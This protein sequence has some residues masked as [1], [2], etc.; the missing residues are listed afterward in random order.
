MHL[1]LEI[2]D[3][4]R[5]PREADAPPVPPKAAMS[6]QRST[7]SSY[8]GL[9]RNGSA[10]ERGTRAKGFLQRLGKDTKGLFDGF[11]GKARHQEDADSPPRSPVKDRFTPTSG[12]PGTAP[13]NNSESPSSSRPG[14]PMTS[15][16]TDKHVEL[17]HKLEH[18]LPSTTP[19]LA[20]PM[21]AVL[22]RVQ[23]ERRLWK[24]K[25]LQETPTA[26]SSAFRLP[27]TMG[28]SAFSAAFGQDIPATGTASRSYRVGGDVRTGLGVLMS[29][30]ETFGGWQKLQRL[31]VLRA[32]RVQP[33]I[34]KL[35]S[36]ETED[37]SLCEKPT[38]TRFA[39]WS[40]TLEES[41]ASFTAGLLEN[42][43]VCKKPG[44]VVE[45]EGHQTLWYHNHSKVI[46]HVHKDPGP[47]V[48]GEQIDAWIKCT[49]CDSR[50]QPRPLTQ[51]AA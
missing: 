3:T 12:L 4:F 5:V 48:A 8:G 36:K 9:K 35:S 20:L 27:G 29:D 14:T 2:L 19:L 45:A 49:R 46:V 34:N 24:E 7:S 11:I 30:I 22:L 26:P 28:T 21:P 39:F 47:E 43:E 33:T 31:D 38:I 42:G 16:S 51:S 1:E 23:E 44:C 25:V 32:T 50:S 37:H 15:S 10:R 13:E 41:I 40:N 17:L 6:V 18:I